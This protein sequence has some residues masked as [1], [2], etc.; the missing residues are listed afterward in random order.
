M[1]RPEEYTIHEI[2]QMI[3]GGEIKIPIFQR[4]YV[5]NKE[6]VENLF[7]TVFNDNPFGA[8]SAIKTTD[9]Y[10]IFASRTFF[11]D[12]KDKFQL[13]EYNDGQNH[14]K[15][16]PL[17]LI[18]DGQQRLQSF[19][20]GLTSKFDDMELCF[21]KKDGL[22]KYFAE[23]DK[24]EYISVKQLYK[25]LGNNTYESVAKSFNAENIEIINQN[26]F[27]FYYHFFFQ[28]RIVMLLAY[29]QN[30]DENDRV[31]LK[32]D[33]K[34]L[35]ELFKRLNTSGINLDKYDIYASK[36]KAYNPLWEKLFTKIDNEFRDIV[37][38]PY[39]LPFIGIN[40]RYRNSESASTKQSNYLH[41]YES[42]IHIIYY[43]FKYK[44]HVDPFY[45]VR[46]DDSIFEDI[47]D[48]VKTDEDI[49]DLFEFIQIVFDL[50]RI[51]DIPTPLMGEFINQLYCEFI[52][53]QFHLKIKDFTINYYLT[54]AKHYSR[55]KPKF[56][57]KNSW[58]LF[59]FKYYLL[60]DLF[61]DEDDMSPHLRCIK[62]EDMLIYEIQIDDN[63]VCNTIMPCYQVRNEMKYKFKF[64]DEIV[65]EEL[66]KIKITFNNKWEERAKKS[67][68]WKKIN[69]N[70]NYKNKV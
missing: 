23:Y 11:E 24:N 59:I 48:C 39:N 65:N 17:Y 69:D 37:Y 7:S 54:S 16:N 43:C 64:A 47:S 45:R 50:C 25:K 61:D 35:F 29:P 66:E 18:L 9:D 57:N 52:N 62:N 55:F 63:V 49:D 36:L 3:E 14:S 33:R 51:I 13:S 8:I 5:W 6:Q 53:N 31:K 32:E 22:F 58:E 38:Y 30:N 1:T 68:E 28:K 60:E 56:V 46:D 15:D 27:K 20:L 40:K 10:P 4:R 19:Y 12:L 42:F 21:N 26:I 44:T 70:Y 34:K 2:I 67:A 41:G